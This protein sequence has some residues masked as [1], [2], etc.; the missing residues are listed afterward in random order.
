M[1]THFVATFLF[2][3]GLV[4]N[5]AYFLG[6]AAEDETVKFDY[7]EEE[8]LGLLEDINAVESWT[9]ETE[10]GVVYTLELSLTQAESED[11]TAAYSTSGAWAQTA[12]AC[13]TKRRMFGASASACS[14]H[15]E[16]LLP[17]EG[18]LRVRAERDGETVVLTDEAVSGTLAVDSARFE[19]G[20]VR[21]SLE[22]SD[23]SFELN[24]S[25]LD[26]LQWGTLDAKGTDGETLRIAGELMPLSA[27]ASS[28]PK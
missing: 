2:L 26:G 10:E 22:G 25:T 11:E 24:G 12:R 6:C 15:Y 18:T 8:M 16:T 5:P 23:G 4:I 3:V 17:L 28:A 21:L 1:N 14:T 19:G 9:V 7:G 20:P 13:G 27:R